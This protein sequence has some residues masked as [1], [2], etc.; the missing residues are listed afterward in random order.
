MIGDR[1]L[2]KKLRLEK[3]KI[4]H[5][6][7][8]NDEQDVVLRHIWACGERQIAWATDSRG[9]HPG[10]DSRCISA[11]RLE[12]KK[13]SRILLPGEKSVLLNTTSEVSTQKSNRNK[14]RPLST[15]SITQ[16]ERNPRRPAT[17]YEQSAIKTALSLGDSEVK[18]TANKKN[19]LGVYVT[20]PSDDDDSASE[21]FNTDH[22]ERSKNRDNASEQQMLEEDDSEEIALTLFTSNDT[23]RNAVHRGRSE[24]KFDSRDSFHDTFESD[25]FLKV[26]KTVIDRDD[27]TALNGHDIITKVE[28]GNKKV[29][30]K[31]KQKYVQIKYNNFLELERPET[32]PNYLKYV[33]QDVSKLT[34]E[35]V[36]SDKPKS[37]IKK[38]LSNFPRLSRSKSRS[39]RTRGLFDKVEGPTLLEIHKHEVEMAD[40]EG[41]VKKFLQKLV[42]LKAGEHSITDYYVSRLLEE[43]SRDVNKNACALRFVS[44][45]PEIEDSRINKLSK[46]PNLT[47]KMINLNINDRSSSTIAESFY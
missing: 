18:L 28:K 17:A 29:E 13:S 40:Y 41:R 42:P 8:S 15:V 30:P 44:Q 7:L 11:V 22:S 47:F 32:T 34:K 5:T 14:P 24:L 43:Q 25:E 4:L 45:S 2:E 12:N 39:Q 26:R 21:L 19:K 10:I 3:E 31:R 46:I 27:D 33:H 36:A 23:E 9:I 16:P 38:D 20:N 6:H 1:Q 37:P 35:K